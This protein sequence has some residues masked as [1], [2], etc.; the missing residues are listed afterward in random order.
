MAKNSSNA[1]N[2]SDVTPPAEESVDFDD[3][4]LTGENE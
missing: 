2:E 1:V 4:T 3:D